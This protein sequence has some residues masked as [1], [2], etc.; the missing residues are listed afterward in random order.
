METHLKFST[1]YHP[2]TDMQSERTIQIIEDMLRVCTIE[3]KGLWEDYLHLAKFS[4][5]NSYKA[6]IKMVPFEALSSR[7]CKYPLC[8]DEVSE[9]RHIG[10]KIIVQTVDKSQNYSRTSPDNIEPVESW[11]DSNRRSLEFK[12]GEQY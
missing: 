1:S 3:I 9:R 2:Q 7:K 4:Y 11:V 5:N 6:S 10:P 12:I 8:W